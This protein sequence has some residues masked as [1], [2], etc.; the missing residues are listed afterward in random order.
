[1]YVYVC[2]CMYKRKLITRF[3]RPRGPT[4][5]CLQAGDPGKQVGFTQEPGALT[6]KVQGQD[7]RPDSYQESGFTLPPY[8]CPT[9]ALTRQHGTHHLGEAHLLSVAR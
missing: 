7:G 8:F 2:L 5:Y 9:Q 3:W 4:I 6:S 1:M